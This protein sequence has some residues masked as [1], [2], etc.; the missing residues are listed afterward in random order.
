M[1]RPSK[2]FGFLVLSIFWL[3]G[4]VYEVEASQCSKE[5]MAKMISGGMSQ[6]RVTEICG[7]AGSSNSIS[8]TALA[9]LRTLAEQGNAEAAFE[10]GIGYEKGEG[11]IRDYVQAYAWYARAYAT[12]GNSKHKAA[13]DAI[14]SKMQPADIEK[15]QKLSKGNNHKSKHGTPPQPKCTKQNVVRWKPVHKTLEFDGSSTSSGL[16]FPSQSYACSLAKKDAHG[17]IF[18][19]ALEECESKL[20]SSQFRNV[21]GKEVPGMCECE[22][23]Q[24]IGL[25]YSCEYK[26]SVQCQAEEKVTEIVEN[27]F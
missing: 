27:C 18:D 26:F 4:P 23:N 19:G 21:T 15:A 14:E 3:T 5:E 10:L 16:G 7:T 11:A 25:G 22:N 9:T 6:K 13:L 8:T 17:S 24:D 20:S 12:S 2:L 1:K